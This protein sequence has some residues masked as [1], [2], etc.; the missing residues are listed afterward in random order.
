MSFL[1]VIIMQEIEIFS[2]SASGDNASYNGIAS[3]VQG[4]TEPI[5]EATRESKY[6]TQQ[7]GG[8]AFVSSASLLN[9]CW[10]VEQALCTS[11]SRTSYRLHSN[12]CHYPV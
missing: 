10:H 12:S 6:E 8:E 9:R 3:H 11:R 7:S 1:H 2:R 4:G 5:H